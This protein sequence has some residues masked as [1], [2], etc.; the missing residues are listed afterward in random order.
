M[1]LKSALVTLSIAGLTA[2]ASAAPLTYNVARTIGAGSVA[3][4]ITT[5]GTFGV[6]A[7]ANV[8]AWSLTLNDGIGSF[9]ITEGNSQFAIVG[10]GLTAD[11]DSMDFNFSGANVLFDF[12][13]PTIGSAI[14]FWCGNGAT[15]VTC[16]SALSVEEVT[17]SGGIPFAAR[18]GIVE[19]ATR[20][21]V[22]GGNSVPEPT[23]LA[24]VGL[25]LFVLCSVHNLY[26]VNG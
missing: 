13:N 1:K 24:L 17:L 20:S 19:I 25:A 23:S 7:T 10:S 15:G 21:T 16:S 8:T 6:L 18:T 26:Y 12:Q 14:N 22:G 9:A 2:A 3:G 11:V 5:D 4:I